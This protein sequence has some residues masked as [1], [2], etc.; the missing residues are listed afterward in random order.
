MLILTD[1]F[2]RRVMGHVLGGIA[3]GV[4]LGYPFGGV[5]YDRIGAATPFVLLSFAIALLLLGQALLFPFILTSRTGEKIT[6]VT[7]LLSDK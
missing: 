1:I 3:L 4:M 6:S 7:R 2:I 5:L